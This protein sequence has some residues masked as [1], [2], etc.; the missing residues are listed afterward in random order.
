MTISLFLKEEPQKTNRVE[1]REVPTTSTHQPSSYDVDSEFLTSSDGTDGFFLDDSEATKQRKTEEYERKKDEKE[2]KKILQKKKREENK[3][4]APPVRVFQSAFD[5]D[6]D[7]TIENNS[8]NNT[9]KSYASTSALPVTSVNADSNL[10]G[11]AARPQV[12]H[13]P[14]E[15]QLLRN[16]EEEGE[17]SRRRMNLREE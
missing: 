1:K 13:E 17:N 14:S 7:E 12:P 8:S 10:L 11:K 4:V 5:N 9:K 16:R 2:R 3:Q 15:V 6:N